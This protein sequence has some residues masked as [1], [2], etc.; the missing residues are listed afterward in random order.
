M[1]GSRPLTTA[2]V[3][4]LREAAAEPRLRALVTVLCY[5][6][7]RMSEGLGLVWGDVYDC[8]AFQTRE[9]VTFR[10]ANVKGQTEGRI[11]PAGEVLR[12]ELDRYRSIVGMVWPTQPLFLGSGRRAWSRSAATRAFDNLL[13]VLGLEEVSSHGCRKWYATELLGRGARMA[14][15]QELLGH[16]DLRTT[17]AYIGDPTLDQLRETVRRLPLE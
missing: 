10:R 12:E 8:R 6:G 3:R 13:E 11:V 16:A 4:A 14:D 1:T 17:S 5:T 9:L 15:V 7:A 2:E